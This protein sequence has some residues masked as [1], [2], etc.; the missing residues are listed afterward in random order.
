[1]IIHLNEL[2]SGGRVY[3]G[4]DSPAIVDFEPDYGQRLV[5][6]I[7][8]VI[9]ATRVPG[10][11]LVEGELTSQAELRCAR[12]DVPFLAEV[13]DSRFER[14]WELTADGLQW[15]GRTDEDPVEDVMDQKVASAVRAP[16]PGGMGRE[17]VDLTADIREA[18]ILAF[19]AYPVC[20]P[21]CKGLCATCGVNLNKAACRCAPPDD[22]RWGVLDRWAPSSR[23]S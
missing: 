4:E 20:S 22:N 7:A 8:Y 10:M 5:A 14:A 9:K 2:T 23:R 13:R 6:P 21:E 18:M 19:P 1:M 15:I 11:L 17:C 12:C 3:R 16:D